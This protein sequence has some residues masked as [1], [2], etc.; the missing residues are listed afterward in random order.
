M[1]PDLFQSNRRK[2]PQPRPFATQRQFPSPARP[3]AGK[4]GCRMLPAL[5]ADRKPPSV[6]PPSG[7]RHSVLFRRSLNRTALRRTVPFPRVLRSTAARESVPAQQEPLQTRWK[8]IHAVRT[9][10]L[11]RGTAAHSRT[12]IGRDRTPYSGVPGA[13]VIQEPQEGPQVRQ[14]AVR[15]KTVRRRTIRYR[16]KTRRVNRNAAGNPA[17]MKRSRCSGCLASAKTNPHGRAAETRTA[18][19]IQTET[20]GGE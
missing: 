3:C 4:M 9:V 2:V 11:L 10:R 18:V 14:T 20:T 12:K 7:T 17:V 16:D 5:P 6:I 1:P 13:Q 8:E 19:T 15:I